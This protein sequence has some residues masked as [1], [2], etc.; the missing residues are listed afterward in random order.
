[1]ENTERRK[2]SFPKRNKGPA[3]LYKPVLN[4]MMTT[5]K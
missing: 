1:M 3:N 5:R 4:K 2:S